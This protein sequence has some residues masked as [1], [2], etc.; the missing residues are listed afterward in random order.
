M[1]LA[2]NTVKTLLRKSFPTLMVTSIKEQPSC[3]HYVV[4][5]NN[6]FIFRFPKTPE[7][8]QRMLR[9]KQL[10]EIIQHR[11]PVAIPHPTYSSEHPT[12]FMGY[13]KIPG[14]ALTSELYHDL[15]AAE[16]DALANQIAQFLYALHNS[17]NHTHIQ[18]LELA[19]AQ[20]PLSSGQLREKLE[21]FV[22]SLGLQKLF[23]YTITI[24]EQIMAPESD[25]VCVHNDLHSQNIAFNQTTKKINGIFDFSDAALGDWYLEFR[26]L[27]LISPTLMHQAAARYAAL[28]GVELDTQRL[29]AYYLATEFS[30]LSERITP[31]CFMQDYEQILARLKKF[32][33]HHKI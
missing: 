7:Y 12:T 13:H 6:Q 18:K 11:V 22:A 16:Q 25:I 10:L 1:M 27:Y 29:I 8:A 21:S 33:A 3:D 24:Y 28:R 19:T 30:R 5:V 31:A 32:A 15:T 20:W 2:P 17:I 26:Y 4:E 23:D 9:E 14:V